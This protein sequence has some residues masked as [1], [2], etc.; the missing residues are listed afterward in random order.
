VDEENYKNFAAQIL[1]KTEHEDFAN[2]VLSGVVRTFY[3]GILDF[4]NA[5]SFHV[6]RVSVN[7]FAPKRKVPPSLG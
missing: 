1:K 3:Q 4:Q 6:T 7:S 2:S 5:I